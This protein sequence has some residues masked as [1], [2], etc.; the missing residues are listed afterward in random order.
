MVTINNYIYIL[1]TETINLN[2]YH[3]KTFL[4]KYG[5]NLNIVSSIE[6][7]DLNY[8]DPENSKDEW[9]YQEIIKEGT[10]NLSL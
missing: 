6:L 5:L 9:Y 3:F 1:K 4:E 7:Q 8:S 10:I 2:N